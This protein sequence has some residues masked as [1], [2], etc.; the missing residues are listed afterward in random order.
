MRAWGDGPAQRLRAA[1]S[2]NRVPGATL[3]ETRSFS[4]ISVVIETFHCRAIDA[5]V[6]PFAT[7]IALGRAP[8]VI[9]TVT[10]RGG[11]TSTTLG[12]VDASATW[13]A[14]ACACTAG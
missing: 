9:A 5:S 12:C 7:T 1:G 2:T 6:W 3:S 14:V 4:I 13:G 11:T 10:G 8:D